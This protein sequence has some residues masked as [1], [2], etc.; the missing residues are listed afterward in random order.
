MGELLVLIG[1]VG[2]GGLGMFFFFDF[3]IADLLLGLHC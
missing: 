2:F 3:L 1:W